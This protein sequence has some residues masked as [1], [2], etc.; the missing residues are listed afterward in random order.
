[1]NNNSDMQ[2]VKKLAWVHHL[3]FETSGYHFRRILFR[4]FGVVK[5]LLTSFDERVHLMLT[6]GVKHFHKWSKLAAAGS[7]QA[8]SRP[9]ANGKNQWEEITFSPKHIIFGSS[10]FANYFLGIEK[11]PVNRK[12]AENNTLSQKSWNISQNY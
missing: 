6:D 7:W 4:I 11:F 3:V 12:T 8:W 1:M 9:M 5:V 10:K 2:K